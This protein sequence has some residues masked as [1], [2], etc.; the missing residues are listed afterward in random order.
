MVRTKESFYSVLE[1]NAEREGDNILVKEFH[2][3][4]KLEF[5]TREIKEKVDKLANFLAYKGVKKGDKVG[6]ML[7][8]SVEFIISILAT[9][10]LGAIPIPM[11]TFLKAGQIEYILKNSSAKALITQAKFQNELI[12]PLQ[13][14]EL[15]AVIWKERKFEPNHIHFNFNEIY[16]MDLPNK[17]A[18]NV[19]LDDV[20]IILYTSGTEGKPKGVMLTYKNLLS[21]VDNIIWAM[22]YNKDDIFLAYLPMFHSFP[23]MVNILTPIFLNARIVILKSVKPFSKVIEIVPQEKISVFIG[24]PEVYAILNKLNLDEKWAKSVRSF[25]VGAAPVYPEIIKTFNKK[26]NTKLYEGYGLTECSP[27]VSVNTEKYYKIGSAGKPLR[28]YKVKIVDEKGNELPP[29]QVGEIAVKGDNVMKGYFKDEE[30]TKKVLRNGW[31]YTGDLG[32]L[33][34]EGFLF[35]KDR[36]KDLI[37]SKGLNIYPREIEEVLLKHPAVEEVA[38]VGKR[39][40]NGSEYPVAFVKIKEGENLTEKELKKFLLKYL[41]YHK[42][43]RHIYFLEE[44][45]KSPT[46]KVQKKVLKEII[47]VLEQHKNEMN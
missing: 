46:G 31:F 47:E 29:Y 27:A 45:P 16:N 43:P 30:K 20:A 40:E 26:F 34:E 17:D 2:L 25:I 39:T 5:T 21:N 8:N 35:I 4:N 22:N 36:K 19:N 15:N 24:V 44:L 18:E 10:K 23:L 6:I 32:Y 1:K 42:L 14:L 38:V 41:S 37:I 3:G 12:I 11:N 9:Q 7:I 33:D 13:N 28:D